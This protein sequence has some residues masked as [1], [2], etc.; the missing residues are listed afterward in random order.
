AVAAFIAFG[1]TYEP[2][3]KTETLP[4]TD[5]V[6]VPE[7][8]GSEPLPEISE[9]PEAPLPTEVSIEKPQEELPEPLPVKPEPEIVQPVE[10]PPEE[11][12]ITI[13]DIPVEEHPV[14]NGTKTTRLGTWAS[15]DMEKMQFE[16]T[17]DRQ[18]FEYLSKITG[19][20]EK[21]YHWF[22]MFYGDGTGIYA[23][24]PDDYEYGTIDPAQGGAAATEDSVFFAWENGGYQ[25]KGKEVDKEAINAA[26]LG[27]I[28]EK[29]QDKWLYAYCEAT[30]S[31]DNAV[32]VSI[33]MNLGNNDIETAKKLACEYYEMAEMAVE[34]KS[35]N[36]EAYSI[37]I[38][39][40]GTPVGLFSTQDGKNYVMIANGKRTEFTAQ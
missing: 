38:V 33:Q 28:P 20:K 11:R 6:E 30:G 31:A 5:T 3:E 21:T 18:L 35:G 39:N 13:F 12:E 22:N 8:T 26:L 9:Q 34:S 36:L 14:M 29:Y 24:S 27:G 15:I 10:E 32:S 4:Q 2:P 23:I 37:S 40:D 16:A 17:P 7:E 19:D 1:L 25:Q